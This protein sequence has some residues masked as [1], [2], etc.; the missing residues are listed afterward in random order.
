MASL[1]PRLWLGPALQL[2]LIAAPQPQSSF[3]KECGM[4][5]MP[6]GVEILESE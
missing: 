4:F 1:H 2:D 5:L 3:S 6:F